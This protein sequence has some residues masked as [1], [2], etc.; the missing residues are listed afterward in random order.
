MSAWRFVAWTILFLS[1]TLGLLGSLASLIIPI[2]LSNFWL[3][4]FILLVWSAGLG[5]GVWWIFVIARSTQ[6]V[7]AWQEDPQGFLK[8]LNRDLPVSVFLKPFIHEL[9]NQGHRIQDS[10][11]AVQEI[12]VTRFQTT[13]AGMRYLMGG[14]VFLGLL[15]T[16]W[17]LSLTIQGI[18]DVMLHL[19][20][21]DI[22]ASG[23]FFTLLKTSLQKPLSGMGT[24][25]GASLF[26]IAASLVLG[27]VDLQLG[28]AGA[29]FLTQGDVLLDHLQRIQGRSLS[30][31]IPTLPFSENYLEALWGHM[32]EHLEKFQ[33]TVHVTEAGRRHLYE[34]LRSLSDKLARLTDQMHT[35]QSLL[36]KLAEGQLDNSAQLKTLVSEFQVRPFHDSLKWHIS[37]MDRIFAQTLH[38]LTDSQQKNMDELRQE[39]RLLTKTLSH[40]LSHK[41]PVHPSL[42]SAPLPF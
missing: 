11:N 3:N 9:R 19:S 2:F 23:D 20:S 36:L 10:K 5:W 24:A 12:F 38:I 40:T 42:T 16:F 22:S 41:P 7:M 28:A 13:H 27:F 8:R 26:G 32:A 18:S 29:H 30:P 37:E 25:F 4:S 31:V 1:V 33:H 34:T 17:G 39:L 21:P 6:T 35:E 14:L 15:G